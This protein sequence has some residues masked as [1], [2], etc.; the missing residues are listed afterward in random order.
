MARENAEK[1][2]NRFR[3]FHIIPQGQRL[4]FSDSDHSSDRRQAFTRA[5]DRAIL[6]IDAFAFTM[7]CIVS[8]T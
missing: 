4:E 6:G 5:N 3:R 8:L 7:Q 2:F 1:A